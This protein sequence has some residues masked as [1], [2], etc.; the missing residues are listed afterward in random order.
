MTTSPASAS[1]PPAPGSGL[2]TGAGFATTRWTLVLRAGAEGGD[3]GT[4]HAALEDLCRSYW[5]P[6]YA[7]LRRQGRSTHDA[8]DLTQGF[9]A[10]LLGQGTLGNAA[11]ER[12]RFRSFLLGALRHHLAHEREHAGARKRGGGAEFVAFDR[13]DSEAGPDGLVSSPELTP[14]RAYDRQWAL[15]LLDR[16]L[17]RLET[18]QGSQGKAS[19]FQALRGTL[20]G[21][22]ADQPYGVLG[23]HLGMSEG[24][25]K[26]AVHR[27]RQRYRDLLRQE[28]AQTVDSPEAVE[29][30][31]R[32]LFAALGG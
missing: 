4:A 29:E 20:V 32:H 7:F 15:A 23:A 18:E 24:A 27:L 16:V 26:V 3:A 30:E 28:I 17:D 10:R 5:R 1:P 8:Q 6:V 14:E 11:P 9:F 22:R 31:L 21:G 25:V 19:Q 12:G 13:P 2:G